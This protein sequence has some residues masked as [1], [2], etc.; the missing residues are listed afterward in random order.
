MKMVKENKIKTGRNYI[1]S[2]A[3]TTTNNNV[4]K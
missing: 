3:L 4:G 2:Q 1:Y